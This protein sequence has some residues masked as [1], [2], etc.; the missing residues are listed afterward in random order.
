MNA[1]IVDLKNKPGELAKAAKTIADRA[2]NVTGFSGSVCGD[3]G[4]A[5]FLTSDE[6]GTRQ[7]LAGGQ[8]KYHEVEYQTVSLADRPG[9]LAEAT[10]RLADAG[11]NIEAVIPTSMSSGNVHLAFLTNNPQKAK[12][13][14]KEWILEPAYSR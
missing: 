11:I 5:V 7:A 9:T 12:E 6:S 10:R 3:S 1:F 13:V 4:T 8:F 14:L 2:I